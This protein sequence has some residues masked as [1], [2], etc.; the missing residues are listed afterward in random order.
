MLVGVPKEIKTEEYRVGLVQRRYVSWSPVDIALKSRGGRARA[1]ASPMKSMSRPAR[2]LSVR[3]SGS[4][5][6]P[7]LS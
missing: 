5:N 1:P 6:V 7:S 4:L 2:R 3:P